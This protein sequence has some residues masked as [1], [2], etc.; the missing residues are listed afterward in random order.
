MRHR[1]HAPGSTAET[2]DKQCKH[3][4]QS[5]RTEVRVALFGIVRVA[6]V[7]RLFFAWTVWRLAFVTHAYPL[8]ITGVAIPAGLSGHI[9][10]ARE[11]HLGDGSR[12]S[13]RVVLGT[14]NQK[15]EK[16]NADG[17]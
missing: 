12:I 5:K 10:M 4:Q 14:R 2:P 16:Q 8:V 11:G 9:T 15:R 7:I 17:R 3:S 13:E 1:F 6:R